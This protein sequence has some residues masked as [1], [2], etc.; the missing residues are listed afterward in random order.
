MIPSVGALLRGVARAKMPKAAS[1]CRPGAVFFG[2]VSQGRQWI[3]RT[4]IGRA[5]ARHDDGGSTSQVPECPAECAEIEVLT[6]A[7]HDRQARPAS[8]QHRQR[9]AHAGM[10][11]AAGEHPQGRQASHA[12][13]GHIDA[14]TLPPPLSRCGQTDEVGHRAARG[15]AHPPK[16][17]AKHTGPSTRRGSDPP[18]GPPAATSPGCRRSDRARTPTS[19]PPAAGG[20]NFRS[21]PADLP[22]P[23]VRGQQAFG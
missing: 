3:E 10:R 19:P 5:T 12:A 11:M 23:R 8:P 16:P 4:G 9:L 14:V 22:R 7:G 13:V 17:P 20:A 18:A 2:K 21:D 6:I 1:T 15:E